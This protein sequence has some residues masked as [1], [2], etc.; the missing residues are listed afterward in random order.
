MI[1][2][3][4]CIKFD[5]IN[6]YYQN[7][8]GLRLS[9]TNVRNQ[10]LNCNYDIIALTETWL[11]SSIFDTEIFD[12]RY[13]IYRRDRE[14]SSISNHKNRGGG[15][16]IAIKKELISRRQSVW[17][18]PSEGLWVSVELGSKNAVE[19]LHICVVYIPPP[20]TRDLL[21]AF[22]DKA[23]DVIS[24]NNL[25]T[26]NSTFL[27]LGDFNMSSF[28]WST[29]T[30]NLHASPGNYSN[31]LLKSSLVDFFTLHDLGQYNAVC[32]ANGKIL[33]LVL[34]NRSITV[35]E[36]RFPIRQ[37]DVLHPPLDVVFQF[38]LSTVQSKPQ[39]ANNREN[40]F[41]FYKADYES[42]IAFLDGIDWISL[43]G[44]LFD[45]D[46]MIEI[47]YGV[48]QEAIDKY[49]PLSCKSARSYPK[50]FTPRLIKLIKQKLKCRKRFKI[51]N[52]PLDAIEFAQLRRD[53]D[54]LIKLCYGQYI[55]E[56]E[57]AIGENPKYF[58]THM[59]NMR[60]KSSNYPAKMFLND[61]E[62]NTRQGICDL[63]ATHFSSVY[64]K[65]SNGSL[66]S[67]Q[68]YEPKNYIGN[69]Y[70]STGDIE[71][72]LKRI[73]KSKST[74]PDNI[75]PIF[76]FHCA[77]S[78]AL[79]LSIIFNTSLNTGIF[80]KKWKEARIVP[81]FK[82]DS[83]NLIE[84]YRPISIISTM[85]KV[86]ESLVYE[87]IFKRLITVK[88]SCRQHGFLSGRSTT[89]NLFEYVT[90]LIN[91]VD[92]RMQVDAI[93]TDFSKAFDRVSFK[94]LIDK[95]RDF[96]LSDVLLGW[97]AS[98]LEERLS[99]VVIDG[100]KSKP[101]IAYSGV[102]QGSILGPAFFN[103]FVNDIVTIF[104]HSECFL[105]ADDLKIIKSIKDE[106][107]VEL[108]QQDLN[109]LIEWCKVNCMYL[110]AKK[111][112]LVRFTRKK[113]FVQSQYFMASDKLSVVGSIRD[114]GVILDNQL[115]FTAHI[116]NMIT[117]ATKLLGFVLRNSKEFR[118]SSTTIKLYNS[119]VRSKLEYCSQIWNPHYKIH[120]KRIENVQKR[121]L[122][123]LAYRANSHQHDKSY[124]QRLKVF[125]VMSLESRRTVSDMMFLY[126]SLNN[127]V[128]SPAIVELFNFNIP[129][130][131][132][133]RS[134]P[135]FK[136]S[137]YKSNLGKYSPLARLQ[138]TYN[139]LSSKVSDL[140]L[141]GND[142]GVFKSKL[143]CFYKDN[144]N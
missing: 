19:H 7:V 39:K 101:F 100:Y 69:I 36:C 34:C 102:P 44:S 48:L 120:C 129:K 26:P 118:H 79:P 47:F 142:L 82:N 74:G 133:R 37:V 10:V 66:R 112:H 107:D 98:Y 8:R 63:F 31:C 106:S 114:L 16:L 35:T 65:S 56:I 123:H 135:L 95:L 80:P 81:V 61:R 9:L 32:N 76:L 72:K 54:N 94:L 41:N 57:K 75:P 108:L 5:S 136:V 25:I 115:K 14:T 50:W 103:I 111:C 46:K 42:I 143:I 125:N 55:S 116:D 134:C 67:H 84:N 51:F 45:V 4:Y 85:S 89:T 27:M 6:F 130:R 77:N 1:W 139:D 110:C 128:D 119:L 96:G 38:S 24:L 91:N 12:D 11:N 127:A 78:L 58:W 29:P 122:R 92:N 30:N 99:T 73:D 105:F 104:K 83:P 68:P 126:K 22:I 109:R 21:H 60:R 59:K 141:N 64:V 28:S 62:A 88:V 117:S 17:E 93:Y 71:K 70:L 124:E 15:V 40:L 23:T 138:R 121:L 113:H 97:C 3:V 52:N 49:V 13:Y 2:V 43:L 33:D 137:C 18:S 20:V 86:F 144:F 131:L 140:D 87:T 53:C 90:K 132:P